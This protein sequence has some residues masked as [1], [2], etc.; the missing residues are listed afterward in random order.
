MPLVEVRR[1]DTVESVHRGALVV[2]DARG[3]VLRTLGDREMACFP[4]SGL[5][6]FQL[7]PFLEAGGRERFALSNAELAVMVGSHGGEAVH[8]AAVTSVLRKVGAAASALGCGAHPPLDP[9]AAAALGG[10]P[11]PLHNNCSG[12]HAGMLAF[13]ALMGW[14]L[15][16]YLDAEHPVQI[17][18]ARALREV[19]ELADDGLASATDGCSAPTYTV[20]LRAV[21]T[22]YA[23][24]ASP[25]AAPERWRSALEVVAR[26]MRAHPAMVGGSAGR[27]DTDLMVGRGGLVA[28]VGAEGFFAVGGPDGTAL[29]LK[30]LDGDPTWRAHPVAIMAALVGLGWV[31]PGEAA[32]LRRYGP[33]VPVVNWAGKR[34]GE[35]RPSARMS[36]LG[37]APSAS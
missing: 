36:A 33:V 19:L 17:A 22:G 32:R 13:A 15:E 11:T 27:L 30:I 14:P 31:D 1:G 20:P 34:T 35:L 18:I 29:V 6:P 8:V 37:R 4:R 23:R 26:A 3:R 12:K 9:S 10:A 7:L 16:G 21:A 25:T 2:G 28:K 5:K 24:L